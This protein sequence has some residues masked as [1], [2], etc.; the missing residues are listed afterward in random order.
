MGVDWPLTLGV[1]PSIENYFGEM[2][3]A[4]GHLKTYLKAN[5]TLI[6]SENWI[7]YELIYT[8]LEFCWSAWKLDWTD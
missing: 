4:P 5:Q 7:T 1:R 8:G 6:W 2:K 3:F